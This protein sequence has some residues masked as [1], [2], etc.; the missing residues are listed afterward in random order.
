MAE[1]DMNTIEI[2]TSDDLLQ[3]L[4]DKPDEW[5][6]AIAAR[7]ALRVLHWINS[8]SHDWL[9]ENAMS[10]LRSVSFSW[11]AINYPAQ[12]FSDAARRAA[13]I[14]SRAADMAELNEADGVDQA[15]YAAA[16]AAESAA[17]FGTN[18]GA[19][20]EAAGSADD[21]GAVFWDAV[22]KDCAWLIARDSSRTAARIL[23]RQ[24]L[25]L[26]RKLGLQSNTLSP[27]LEI[28][29][30]YGIWLVWHRRRFRGERAAFDIPGDKRRVEDKKILRRLAEATDEDFWGKGHEYVNATL[31]GWLEEARAR[32]A[33]PTPETEIETPPQESGAIAYGVNDQGKLDRLPHSDQAHLRD[34]P[35]QRQVYADLR[36]TARELCDEGQRLGPRLLPKGERFICSL[37]ERFEDALLYSVWRDGNALRVLLFE[38]VAAAKTHEP[39]AAKLDPVIAERLR[40]LLD[41]YNNFAFADDGLRGKDEARI[42]PQERASGEAEA[43]AANPLVAAILAAPDIATAE[44]FDDIAADAEDANRPTNDP[45][46]GQALDQANSMRR[47]WIAGF[48]DGVRKT[49]KNPKLLGKRAAIGVATGV[50]SGVGLI[51]LNSILGMNYAPLLEF[52]ATNA[53]ALQNYVAVAFSSYPLLPNLVATITTLWNRYKNL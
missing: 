42:P 37:P 8:A 19:A 49:I 6:Q 53:L 35:D 39:D 15:A 46:A 50:A 27:L 34:L 45:Y 43:A 10:V 4:E 48:L 44:A 32:V 11:A 28:D 36:E 21:A 38:H 24:S 52:V 26:D 2:K 51:T 16:N 9:K 25:W 18:K 30:N 47:N 29:T 31:K 20:A 17:S 13:D 3:W 41:L 40:G 5:A 7:S 1:E 14:C 23:S 22:R 33:P 12:D